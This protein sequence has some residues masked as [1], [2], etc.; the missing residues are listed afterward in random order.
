MMALQRLKRIRNNL[1]NPMNALRR[2]REVLW[3]SRAVKLK[4]YITDKDGHKGHPYIVCL[5][6]Y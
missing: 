6:K 4:N 5:I 1:E 2:F 3:A